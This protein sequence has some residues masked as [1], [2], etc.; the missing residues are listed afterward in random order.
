MN[1]RGIALMLLLSIAASAADKDKR[2][3]VNPAA[4]YPNKQSGAGV[5]IAA[6][7]FTTDEQAKTAFGKTNPY[8]HGV[9]PVLL[10][11]RNESGKTLRLDGMEA[12]YVSPDKQKIDS[13]PSADVPYLEGAR[14]P[15]FGSPLPPIPIPRGKKKSKLAIPEIDGLSFAAKM[16]PDGEQA[17]GFFYFQ[18]GYRGGSILYVRGLVEAPTGKELLY[19]EVPLE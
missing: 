1:T 7:P 18:T 19:F 12:T 11:V 8:E 14:R 13:T 6:V 3:R 15:S 10:I 16:L 9:L 5:T 2:L 17:H 4:S